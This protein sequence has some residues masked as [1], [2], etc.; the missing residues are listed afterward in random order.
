MSSVAP[1]TASIAAMYQDALLAHHRAPHNRRVIESP[2]AVGARKN[3]VCGDDITVMVTLESDAVRD[4]AFTGRGCSIATASASM[5]TD[6]VL[7]LTVSDAL[8]LA[9][10]VDRM[11]HPDAGQ[12]G[13]ADAV[14]EPLPDALTPLRG[15]APFPGRHG[16]AMLPWQALREAL[17]AKR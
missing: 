3:P 10:A 7:G 2:S 5:M 12:A 13:S 17:T 9:D 14:P 11:L 15:V 16:C 8:A 4:V 1:F 6:A